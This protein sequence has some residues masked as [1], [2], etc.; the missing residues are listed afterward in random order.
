LAPN[1]EVQSEGTKEAVAPQTPET[2]PADLTD[3]NIPNSG[4]DPN[5][6]RVDDPAAV[7]IPT[8][9][10]KIDSAGNAKSDTT[11]LGPRGV[12]ANRVQGAKPA[13]FVAPSSKTVTDAVD[14]AGNAKS[15]GDVPVGPRG[16][17]PFKDS[18]RS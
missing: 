2:A 5:A 10:D 17:T 18:F 9:T 16:A 4:N 7:K 3:A 13:P 12:N 11:P 8:S 1:D 6:K 15:D 14:S